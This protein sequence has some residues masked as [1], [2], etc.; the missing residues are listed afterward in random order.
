M[1]P[2]RHLYLVG[3]FSALIMLFFAA[4]FLDFIHRNR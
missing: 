3:W 2:L 4:L 1:K